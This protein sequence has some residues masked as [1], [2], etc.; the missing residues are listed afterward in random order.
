MTNSAPVTT[1]EELERRTIR[2]DHLVPDE[3][4]FID[5]RLPGSD[6]KLNYPLIGAGVSENEKQ[7]VPVTDPH[8]FSLGAA[9]MPAGVTNSLHLHFTAEVFMCFGGEW[10]FRWGIDGA[11]GEVMVREGDVI[12]IPTWIF[13]GFTSESDDS[14]LYTALG[15]DRSGGLIWAPSVL[16][17]AAEL[18]MYLTAENRI[19]DVGPGN[20]PP[21]DARLVEPLAEEDFDVLRS[22]DPDEMR[23]RLARP[24]DLEWSDRPFLDS[25]LPEGGAELAIV[26][27]YGLTEDRDQRPRVHEPHGLSLAWLRAEPGRGLST[28]RHDAAQAVIVKDGRWKVTL[29]H[30][31]DEVDVEVGPYDTVSVPAGA[32]RRFQSVGDE[33]GQ[34]AVI[35]EGDGKVAIDWHPDVAA[36]ARADGVTHD[37]NG[38]LAPAHLVDRS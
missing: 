25:T 33:Q 2:Y 1:A 31:D 16:E 21:D 13:R 18:G 19:L 14:W 37:A 27:G 15:R 30:G 38:Y 9:V 28:H 5:T 6:K 26:V 7:V 3:A 32:W 8:G 24:E 17:R 35:T 10:R 29:N 4:A 22:V 12:S 36:A 11:D 34:L 20:P 23:Q